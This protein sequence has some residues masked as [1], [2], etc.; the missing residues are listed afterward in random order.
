MSP[1]HTHQLP[2][3]R[4]R[5]ASLLKEVQRRNA[6]RKSLRETKR[7]EQAPPTFTFQFGADATTPK[8]SIAF[9]FGPATLFWGTCKSTNPNMGLGD[10]QTQVES[11]WDDEFIAAVDK[12]VDDYKQMSDDDSSAHKAIM[13]QYKKNMTNL[14]AVLKKLDENTTALGESIAVFEKRIDDIIQASNELCSK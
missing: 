1:P 8:P 7:K 11:D 4:R 14:G 5:K 9:T 3:I 12:S 6:I 13:E 2:E 10:T